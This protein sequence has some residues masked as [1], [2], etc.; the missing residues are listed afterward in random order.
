MAITKKQQEQL[1]EPYKKV[2]AEVVEKDVFDY[3]EDNYLPFSWSVCLDRSLVLTDGLKPIQR[4]ILWTAYKNNITDK[5]GKI[6]SATFD[7]KVLEYS[8]HGG[9]LH[10][11]TL[12]YTLSHGPVT[13]SQLYSDFQKYSSPTT[14]YVL[15][16]HEPS[17]P[18]L[19]EPEEYYSEKFTFSPSSS[20]DPLSQQSTSTIPCLSYNPTTNTVEVG[21]ISDVW[22]AK[23]VSHLIKLNTSDGQHILATDNHEFYI[24][25]KGFTHADE[26]CPGDTLYSGVL[27]HE[28]S[29]DTTDLFT[30]STISV[31][32][33]EIL[34]YE[35]EIPV[36]D[37]SEE[38]NHNAFL[39]AS[40]VEKQDG[41]IIGCVAC[42]HNSYGSI[43]N[44]AA[45][46]V[47]GQP[48]SMRIPLI[49]GRGNWGGA[50]TGTTP[51]AA[52]FTG[53]T[54]IRHTRGDI[55][56]SD[57]VNRFNNHNEEFTVYAFDTQGNMHERKVTGASCN[58]LRDI[59]LVT[60][61]NQRKIRC[62][63]DHRFMLSDGT[64]KHA[65][66]LTSQ[67]QLMTFDY[68]ANGGCY[69]VTS[70]EE[71]PDQ[72]LV[73]D[74][75]VEEFHNFTLSVGVVVH[76]SRYTELNLWPAAMELLEELSEDAV[77]LVPNYNNTDVEPVCLPV[78]WPVAFI[79]GVPNA[80]AVGFACNLPSHNPDE[81][82]DACIALE[83]NNNLTNA[84]LCKI[85]KGP[86]F[87]CGCD[88]ITTTVRDGKLVDGVKSYME[89][90]SGSFIMR[91]TYELEEHNGVY[92][93][94]FYKLPYKL[95]PENIVEELKKQYEKGNF[96]EIASWKDLS[97]INHPIHLEITTKRNININK[98]IAD[99]YKKTS[100]QL[101]FAAN[102]TIVIDNTPTKSDART[103]LL[104]FLKFRKQCTVRKLNYRLKNF[105]HKLDMQNAIL[106]VLVDIDK[107]IDIIRNSTNESAAKKNLIKTFSI[108]EEQASYILSM[109]LRKL[110]K[111]DSLEIK[112]TVRKL[113]SDIKE[114]QRVL[115]NDKNISEFIVSEL[116]ETKKKISSPR[117][118]KIYKKLT[119][120]TG[121]DDKDV[122]LV[123]DKKAKK[124]MRTFEESDDNTPSTEL[125]R[126]GKV[127]VIS[128]DKGFIRSVYELPDNKLCP[129][130]RFIKVSKPMFVAPNKGKL[131]L[132]SSDGYM[133]IAD[134]DKI[135]K[136][137]NKDCFDKILGGPVVFV[138]SIDDM[139]GRIVIN[140]DE[141]LIDIQEIPVQSITA[142]G[143]RMFR[144][145][146]TKAAYVTDPKKIASLERKIAKR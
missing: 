141:K 121:E 24:L 75:E 98:V 105:Q 4:R 114:I 88:I 131:L 87:D 20:L 85:I 107:C 116:E 9:C 44:M 134:M 109:Q 86:D 16:S 113:N 126:E 48:R 117:K 132:V 65:I 30:D 99:L 59:V 82:M 122:Y 32:S 23:Y 78:K 27:T 142:R 125:D 46:E 76:N 39:M 103:I 145:E 94:H 51:A 79:N 111:S 139:T 108:N 5:S 84:D 33:V 28:P 95:G 56:I 137:P 71:L 130:T 93:I 19:F 123:F 73:Y 119:S 115:K 104:E 89:T 54:L 110:T 67:D 34:A 80:M 128:P 77:D 2:G 70:V 97:D 138:D 29:E 43:V 45:P 143:K 133:K 92:T 83:R 74:I 36:Y 47:P 22:I 18:T 40:Y 26:I 64:Y 8:P 90:G 50:N 37:F 35:N 135:D 14:D 41:S 57:L 127:L 13:I 124:V 15:S 11:D 96:K 52:C 62:T 1:E 42:A 63:P 118:C 3:V 136:F 60:L 66:D 55:S 53:N 101:V 7:G 102:N 61:N 81:V 21:H 112:K 58:G 91:A 106:A 69:H 144:G 17:Q 146:I 72:E 140:G 25:S 12:I 31:T 129:L 6:K 120:T 100:L 38:S 10:P 68:Y 49:R